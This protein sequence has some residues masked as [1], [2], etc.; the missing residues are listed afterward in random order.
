MCPF[1]KPDGHDAGRLIDEFVPSKATMIDYIVIGQED[2]FGEPVFAHELPDIFK[3][4]EFRTFGRNRQQGD[5]FWD[6]EF[7]RHLPSRLIKHQ[8]GMA[9]WRNVEA[10]LFEL[11]L[12]PLAVATQRS[13]RPAPLPSAGQIY[14]LTGAADPGALIA[15]FPALPSG[16]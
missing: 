9:A 5:V 4:I 13:T 15:G 8:G 14:R 7:V 2:T 6:F 10:Y 16:A 1:A 11:Q 3:R 12:H